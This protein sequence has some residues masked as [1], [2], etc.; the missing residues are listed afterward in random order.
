MSSNL[1]LVNDKAC[2]NV[3]YHA[4]SS[5]K[6]YHFSKICLLHNTFK[7]EIFIATMSTTL[8]QIFNESMLYSYAVSNYP[9][10]KTTTLREHY[11]HIC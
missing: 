4:Y 9:K 10:L 5:H 6:K 7:G 1:P 2:S 8:F 3:T 11:Q